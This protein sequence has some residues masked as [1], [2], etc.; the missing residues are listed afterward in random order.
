MASCNWSLIFNL[1]KEDVQFEWNFKVLESISKAKFSLSSLRMKT[2]L[3]KAK[4]RMIIEDFQSTIFLDILKFNN[5]KSFQIILKFINSKIQFEKT[6]RE[7][8]NKSKMEKNLREISDDLID[9][10]ENIK[11]IEQ[12]FNLERIGE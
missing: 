4:N 11:I 8:K 9:M 10:C 7:K 1:L 2:K 6:L 3:V 12:P 5:D